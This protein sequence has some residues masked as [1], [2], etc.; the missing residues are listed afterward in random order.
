[1]NAEQQKVYDGLEEIWRE[2]CQIII[3]DPRSA[4]DWEN[5]KSDTTPLTFEL[6]NKASDA[7]AN[8]MSII[9]EPNVNFMFRTIITGGLGNKSFGEFCQKSNIDIE[10]YEIKGE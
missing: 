3:Q 1:M 6:I 2:L 7:I 4:K 5:W 9:S 10:K 8:A